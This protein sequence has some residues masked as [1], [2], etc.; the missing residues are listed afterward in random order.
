MPADEILR[1]HVAGHPFDKIH[2]TRPAPEFDIGTVFV[3]T[4]HPEQQQSLH[5]GTDKQYEQHSYNLA[6]W[7]P[8]WEGCR[9]PW[10]GCTAPGHWRPLGITDFT[11]G[12]TSVIRIEGSNG[13]DLS[14]SLMGHPLNFFE[15]SEGGYVAIQGVH[16]MA[17]PGVYPM[18]IQGSL[19][20]E[21]SFQLARASG[22]MQG[23]F[24][25]DVPL[26]VAAETMD[27]AITGPENE[28]WESQVMQATSRETVGR[29]LIPTGRYGL[30]RLLAIN[31]WRPAILQ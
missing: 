24:L 21:T 12:Q 25:Y 18:T 5:A 1:G 31:F 22:Y 16:A 15:L 6:G 26:Y 13:I 3:G 19:P 4:G 8:A 14:G 20:D 28:L 10:A 17:D 30:C 27:P 2:A 11:Q 9:G 29:P 23:I 7:S